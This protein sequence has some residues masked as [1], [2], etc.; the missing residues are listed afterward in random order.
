MKKLLK[1]TFLVSSVATVIILAMG[2]MIQEI[3]EIDI[4][5]PNLPNYQ[6]YATETAAVVPVKDSGS[7]LLRRMLE[8]PS[9]G[10]GVEN[11]PALA[12]R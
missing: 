8:E 7:D 3:K 1:E 9:Q 5:S 12:E 10:E 4:H 2:G 6:D 11:D